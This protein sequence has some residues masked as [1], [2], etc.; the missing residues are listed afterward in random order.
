MVT[1][2]EYNIVLTY[3]KIH[4]YLKCSVTNFD[5][6]P[7]NDSDTWHIIYKVVCSSPFTW[8]GILKYCFYWP[9]F[10]RMENNLNK[11]NKSGK[12]VFPA[13]FFHVTFCSDRTEL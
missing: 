13:D 6:L 10:T 3:W 4:L 8:C 5:V 9:P 7:D 11:Y 12:I 2:P 1:N